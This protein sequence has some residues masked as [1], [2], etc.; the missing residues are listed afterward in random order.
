MRSATVVIVA[1]SIWWSVVWIR[2]TSFAA[3]VEQQVCDVRADYFLGVENYSEAIRLHVEVVHRHPEDALA[4]YHLGFALGMVGQTKAE[5][6][7]YLTAQALGLE[8]WDLFLNLGLAQSE[9]GDLEGAGNSLRRS[10]ILGADH[11]E[12]HFN[13]A[14]VD[15]RRG[16]LNDAEHEIWAALILDPVEPDER[17]LLGVIYAD[18]G[19]I[20]GAYSVWSQLA[21]D[22]PDY[23]PARKN[24]ASLRN[25]PAIAISEANCRFTVSSIGSA[26]DLEAERARHCAER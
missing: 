16:M 14:L 9:N 19:D 6:R 24:L 4:H 21:R 22:L 1:V 13:L 18:K 26:K 15:E 25:Q 20:A 11:P 10:T 7:E 12:S 8:T 17:N 23:E 5:I 3:D 2:T